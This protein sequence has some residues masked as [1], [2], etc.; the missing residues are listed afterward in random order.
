ME[1]FMSLL[2]MAT[3]LGLAVILSKDRRAINLRTVG[4]AFAIQ[5]SFGAMM[6][7]WSGADVPDMRLKF[8]DETGDVISNTDYIAGAQ[9]TWLLKED[10]VT[11]PELTRTIRCELRGTRNEGT[12]ND[13]YFDD[14]FVR[15]GN[16]VECNQDVVSI[17]NA[18]LKPLKFNAYP[19]P[20]LEKT[21]VELP[22]SWGM[23][24]EVRLTDTTGKKIDAKYSIENSKLHLHRSSLG[25]GIYSLI[26]INSNHW[27]S[28]IVVFE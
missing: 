26:I 15:I 1:I 4:G 21:T 6:S 7:D 11:I 12:D 3:L 17:E 10:L 9:T 28:T 16:E 20:A 18:N 13:S 19:N 5:V 22:F 14:V 24:T 23:E 25:S 8:M 27:G 2:G